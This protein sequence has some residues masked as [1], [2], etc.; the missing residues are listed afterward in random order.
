MDDVGI[1]VY[2][3]QSRIGYFPEADEILHL[4]SGATEA[5]MHQGVELALPADLQ[6][7]LAPLVPAKRSINQQLAAAAQRTDMMAQEDE[8]VE[9]K[10]PLIS[11]LRPTWQ[12]PP[13]KKAC[14]DQG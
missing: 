4:R 11:E 7:A 10:R 8:V 1:D 13:G 3:N 5:L 12:A 14:P 2:A 6:V 9:D